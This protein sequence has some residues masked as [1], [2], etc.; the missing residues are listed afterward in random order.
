MTVRIPTG[1]QPVAAG[2][3]FQ[4]PGGVNRTAV[5]GGAPRYA[6][7]W[8]RGPSL[9]SVSM[10]LTATQLSVWQVF[11]HQVLKKGAITFAM[12]LDSGFGL[13]DHDCNIT[14]DSYRVARTGG[15]ISTVSFTVEATSQA[16]DFSAAGSQVLLDLWETY[17]EYS[18][19]LLARLAQFANVNTNVLAV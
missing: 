10:V 18:W 4:G 15:P 13:A 8:D 19:P 7:A 2:Y 5:A 3:G 17:G 9:F 11:Y 12:P 16:Y 6:L 14:P 1:F